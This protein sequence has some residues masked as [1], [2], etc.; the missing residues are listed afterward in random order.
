MILTWVGKK[1]LL[2]SSVRVEFGMEKGA[3]VT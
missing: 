2:R 1:L 3:Y